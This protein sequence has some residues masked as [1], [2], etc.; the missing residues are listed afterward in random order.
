MKILLISPP[1]HSLY[2]AARVIIPPLGLLYVAG[3]STPTDTR[4]KCAI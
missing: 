2:F 4:S 3:N 1:L